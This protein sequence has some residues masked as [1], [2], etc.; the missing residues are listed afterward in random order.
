ME[1]KRQPRVHVS[2]ISMMVAVPP[3]QHSPMLGHRASSQ[4]VASPAVRTVLRSRWYS[5]A[6]AGSPAGRTRSQ[7]GLRGFAYASTRSLAGASGESRLP[8]GAS[9]SLG[10]VREGAATVSTAPN[11]EK[12][13]AERA[14]SSAAGRKAPME[15][16]P[17]TSSTA[18]CCRK[19]TS[20]AP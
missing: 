7:S 11:V 2:P 1:Q 4:T 3:P 10:E 6:A 9:V 14:I 15:L 20:R 19:A 16:S 17:S 5:D 13:A 12:G 18:N 8:P